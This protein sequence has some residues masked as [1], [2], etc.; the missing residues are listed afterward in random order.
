MMLFKMDSNLKSKSKKAQG[1]PINFIILAS[2]GILVLVLVV[3]FLYSGF[4]TEGVDRQ[5]A[6]NECSSRCLLEVQWAS[7]GGTFPK[8]DSKYCEYNAD[9]KGLGTNITCLE[10][11]PCWVEDAGCFI[12]C[13]GTTAECN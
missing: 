4:R 13:T 1:L 12:S 11:V 5:K 3:M 8:N 6:L 10:L 9:V 7:T 2:I